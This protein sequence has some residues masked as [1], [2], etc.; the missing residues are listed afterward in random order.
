MNDIIRSFLFLHKYLKLD[1]FN[2][3][4]ARD[5]IVIHLEIKNDNDMTV[6]GYQ[7]DPSMDGNFKNC[8]EIK[9]LD[10]IVTEAINDMVR[11][12]WKNS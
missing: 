1:Y 10:E 11:I 4:G 3:V 7:C 2:V 5:G 9:N 6:T 8:T 12:E